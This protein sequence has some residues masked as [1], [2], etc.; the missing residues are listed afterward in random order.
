MSLV[1]SPE[2][3]HARARA[4]KAQ[5]AAEVA[6]LRRRTH[7]GARGRTASVLRDL[8]VRLDPPAPEPRRVDQRPLEAA[9]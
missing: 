8:A 1:V 2:R 7:R 4:A 9:R 5:R 6:R 3:A